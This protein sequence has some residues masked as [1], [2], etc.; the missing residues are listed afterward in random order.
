MPSSASASSLRG[1]ILEQRRRASNNELVVVGTSYKT[2][3]L[4]FREKL[5]RLVVTKGLREI[6]SFPG[7]R[8]SALLSTCNR[9]ELYLVVDSPGPTL[10]QVL[11]YIEV[12][13]RSASFRDRVYVSSGPAAIG[14][15]FR[16]AAGL[17]SI[18]L[19]EPQILAQ[20]RS[21]GISSRKA[22]TAK[23]ILSPLFD[24]AS[25][26]GTHVRAMHK[27]GSGEAS[28]S[29]LAVD[30]VLESCPSKPAVL[31]VGTG[32][33]VQLAA[34]RLQGRASLFYVAS[35][36]KKV[37]KILTGSK[38]IPYG[39]IGEVAGRCDVIISAAASE[40]PFLSEA[41]LRGRRRRVVVDLGMP[42]NVS[43]SARALPNVRL[44][45]LDDLARI[46]GRNK[47]TIGLR[48]ADAVVA[49][50]AS[51][52]HSWLIQTRL[53]ST[54]SELFEWAN[55]VRDEEVRRA[56]HRLSRADPRERRILEAMARR[57]VSKLMARPVK[58]ARGRYRTVTEEEKLD[59]L[60][61]VFRM[62]DE[63]GEP[64]TPR[65]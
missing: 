15:L 21:A 3:D 28:L 42:R 29:D 30:I 36:R 13:I 35:R 59:L 50:E 24:R 2:A 54:I 32:K 52:F 20:V 61:S 53:T 39:S 56:A 45:D 11:D 4:Q 25:R 60:R 62:G 27:I 7:V 12:A 51:E 16:V 8:E 33:M 14:H 34:K 18:V 46:G 47:D 19:G 58:F 63:D 31:L 38:L 26:V 40:R 6:Q 49:R 5:R 10:E 22:H 9:L 37:P 65:D 1:P 44:V 48:E 64:A 41:N 43:S 57:I 55:A 23:G 17:D